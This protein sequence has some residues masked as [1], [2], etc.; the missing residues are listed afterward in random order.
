MVKTYTLK[1]VPQ[2]E[3]I[4]WWGENFDEV[5]EFLGAV[6]M[7]VVLRLF[8]QKSLGTQKIG[9][10]VLYCIMDVGCIA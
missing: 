3:A 7:K 8:S 5:K 6:M 9:S 4:Q 2:L 10:I 1:D